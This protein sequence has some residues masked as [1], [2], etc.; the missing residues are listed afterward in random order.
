MSETTKKEN[1]LSKRNDIDIDRIPVGLCERLTYHFMKD[2]QV[3][4][5]EKNDHAVVVGCVS[6]PPTDITMRIMWK[7]GIDITYRKIPE[8]ILLNTMQ[9][10]FSHTTQQVVG[11][12][13]PQKVDSS[14]SQ[15]DVIDLLD[16]DRFSSPASTVFRDICVDGISQGVSDIHIECFQSYATVRFR[17]DGVLQSRSY[18][19]N[20]IYEQLVAYIK[21]SSQLDVA[22]KRH[23]QDGRMF[24]RYGDKS[25]DLRISIIPTI[26]SERVVIRLLDGSNLSI[27]LD[28]LG[29]RRRELTLF[30]SLMNSPEGIV[31]VTGPTG[32][33]KTTTLYSAL[34]VLPKKTLN[35]MTLEDPVEYK[36]DGISQIST[37]QNDGMTFLSG[38]RSMLR[39]DP[40][41]MMIGEIR[42]TET[43]KISLRASL[44][45]HL[46]LTT[47]HTNSAVASIVRLIDMGIEPYMV[48]ASLRGV[49]AQRLLRLVC[50]TCKK[51]VTPSKTEQAFLSCD[52]STT[53]YKS[54]GC[55]SC[56]NSGYK[57]RKGVYE[58][59]HVSD[60]IKNLISAGASTET[61]LKQANKEGMIS[62]LEQ[63][64]ALVKDGL[65]TIEELNRVMGSTQGGV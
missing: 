27:D 22:D 47:L 24:V 60:D 2:H 49:L 8:K 42:D 58:L 39:Q 61:L 17:T 33:G 18:D 7:L 41:V 11:K 32:S 29:M 28:Q 16:D 25:V 50:P 55:E 21:I 14:D 44:T 34:D 13:T 51:A 63:G 36:I 30:K 46:I 37:Q 20:G 52:A 62:L 48:A 31:L 12:S 59:F 38:L 40:D 10:I 64:K 6:L 54:T 9:R 65:T 57:G 45:G 56:Y 19:V 23:S 43:A 35:I 15:N 1:S 5:L 53:L 3:L 26:H 4:P